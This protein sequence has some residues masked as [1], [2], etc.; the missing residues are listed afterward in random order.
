MS[1]KKPENLFEAES[2]VEFIACDASMSKEDIGEVANSIYP[3][4]PLVEELVE[5]LRGSYFVSEALISSYAKR[6]L[7]LCEK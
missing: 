7:R 4:N 3:D 5:E 1:Y 2:L 6:L